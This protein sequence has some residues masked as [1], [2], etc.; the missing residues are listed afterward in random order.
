MTGRGQVGSGCDRDGQVRRVGVTGSSR[1][2]RS[3][4]ARACRDG[5]GADGDSAQDTG[6]A[7]SLRL[8]SYSLEGLRVARV[9]P[10]WIPGLQVGCA[11]ILLNGPCSAPWPSLCHRSLCLW[12]PSLPIP[13]SS[14]PFFQKERLPPQQPGR[15]PTTVLFFK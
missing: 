6:S 5:S 2:G 15:T 1:T 13:T 12:A 3:M 4:L 9:V 7:V 11:N 14:L 8:P 10:A